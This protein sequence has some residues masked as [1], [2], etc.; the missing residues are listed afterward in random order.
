M[1]FLTTLIAASVATQPTATKTIPS[2][3]SLINQ[4]VTEKP[5]VTAALNMDMDIDLD[6]LLRTTGEDRYNNKHYVIE[7]R[8]ITSFGK[9]I[10]DPQFT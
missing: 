5:S 7:D 2:T 6:D 4:A 8:F 10:R 3:Q 9:L 1:I